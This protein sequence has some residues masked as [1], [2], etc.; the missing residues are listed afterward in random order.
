[1]T[2]TVI[3]LDKQQV[4][5]LEQVVIDEDAEGALELVKDIRKK[6]AA[7]SLRQCDPGKLRASTSVQSITGNRDD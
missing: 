2:E 7:G 4:I 6:I 1:M 5:R 3:T